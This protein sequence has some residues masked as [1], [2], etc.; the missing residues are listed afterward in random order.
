MGTT[1]LQFTLWL[2]Y[3][4]LL[5]SSLTQTGNSSHIGRV[6][7]TWGHYHWKTFDGEFFQ[8]AS[9]CNHVVASQ[10][11][12]SYENFN[13]QMRR[14]IVN[15]IPTISKIII[16]LEGSVAE[17]SSSAVIFNGKT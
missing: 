4:T 16:M 12:G 9:T 1:G 11:K 2:I 6:C 3:L 5:V 14:K 17:L 15:D 8:L 10:C 13:I 7:T